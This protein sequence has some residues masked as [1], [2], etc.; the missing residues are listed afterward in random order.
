[1]HEFING[2]KRKLQTK[3]N[4]VKGTPYEKERYGVM[5]LESWFFLILRNQR[6]FVSS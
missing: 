4:K 6:W 2:K 5:G 3:I 1:M